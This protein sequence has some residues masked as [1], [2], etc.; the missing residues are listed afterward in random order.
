[1][2]VSVCCAGGVL[3]RAGLGLESGVS[4][5]VDGFPLVEGA[6]ASGALWATLVLLAGEARLALTLFFVRACEEARRRG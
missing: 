1:V 4:F 6:A 2:C 5:D 3:F